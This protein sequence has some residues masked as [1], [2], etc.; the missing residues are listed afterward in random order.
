MKEQSPVVVNVFGHCQSSPI[1]FARPFNLLLCHGD[2]I[3]IAT[4]RQ[5]GETECCLQF[6]FRRTQLAM[7]RPKS[8]LSN[9]EKEK[10]WHA[11]KFK[12]LDGVKCQ[13]IQKADRKGADMQYILSILSY[14]IAIRSQKVILH[15][16][17]RP[18]LLCHHSI[19]RLRCLA[20]FR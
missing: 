13:Y 3:G 14:V 18:S 17:A 10:K 15:V 19:R 6:V 8:T 9:R 4:T 5:I 1:Y 16:I 11:M 20:R 2:V 7:G 12:L